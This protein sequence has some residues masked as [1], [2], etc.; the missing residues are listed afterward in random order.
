MTLTLVQNDPVAQSIVFDV[1]R[2]LCQ[3]QVPMAARAPDRAAPLIVELRA[4]D[5]SGEAS[6]PVNM[7]L[8]R[9]VRE[10]ADVAVGPESQNLYALP[11]PVF[12]SPGEFRAIVL[13]SA[14]NLYRVYAAEVGGPD[15]VHGGFI[16]SQ[17]IPTGIFMDSSNNV[18]WTPHQGAD[19]R[20]Q[21]WVAR[22][23]AQ[24]AY[25]YL[26]P[27]TSSGM[28]AFYLLVDQ[29]VPEGTAVRWEYSID[30][31]VTWTAC[32]PF[33]VTELPA[34][35][36]TLEFRAILQSNSPYVSP[37]VHKNIA[38]LVQR[39][40][41]AASYVSTRTTLTAPKTAFE[42]WV[43]YVNAP[44]GTTQGDGPARLRPPCRPLS[45]GPPVRRAAHRRGPGR[46]AVTPAPPR[47]RR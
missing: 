40:K 46:D 2:M 39:N 30:N 25:L 34:V 37:A 36:G 15:R 14:S 12:C 16:E 13:R 35:A 18:D 6:T 32:A 5:R 42:G 33:T 9:W 29:A 44:G 22:M 20:C 26:S 38:V 31:R 11:D 7:V 24:A 27:V 3:V 8:G 45:P 4:T 1:P 21:V 43:E 41:I 10:A 28:T 19:L 47:P 17:Q 23:T